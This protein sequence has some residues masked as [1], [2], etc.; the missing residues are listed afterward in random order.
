MPSPLAWNAAA[1][2]VA[3]LIGGPAQAEPS[4]EPPPAEPAS[5]PP[6]AEPASEPPAPQPAHYIIHVDLGPELARRMGLR[7]ILRPAGESFGNRRSAV[8]LDLPRPVTADTAPQPATLDLPA[9]VWRI[10]AS[11]P[12][13]L[14][15]T[16]EFSVDATRP[17]QTLQWDLLPDTLHADVTV[18]IN[19]KGSPGVAVVARGEAGE[20]WSCTTQYAPCTFRLARG[21]WTFEARARGFA[22][23]RSELTVADNRPQTAPMTLVPGDDGL[24]FTTG[25][26]RPVPPDIRKRLVLGLGLSAAPLFGGGLALTIVG[27]T[28]YVAAVR[29]STCEDFGPACANAMIGPTHLASAGMGM[30]GAAAGLLVTNVTGAFDVR[31]PVWWTLLGVGGALTV[32]GAAW[33]GTNTVLLDRALRSGPLSE[34]GGHADRRLAASMLLGLG[35]GTV[36]GTLTTLLVVRRHAAK[37]PKV[38]AW[39]VPGQAGVSLSGRF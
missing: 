21:R 27:R 30:L 33:T 10:E 8:A 32:G 24:S 26:K 12:G 25:P 22:P 14:P 35:A 29:G 6:P 11:A 7:V 23:M 2:L 38:G 39:A 36:V 34:A 31:R 13:F 19:A 3:A 16:R 37:A 20:E 4:A 5:E 9:G 18:P 15:S 1:L 17:Q 28:R